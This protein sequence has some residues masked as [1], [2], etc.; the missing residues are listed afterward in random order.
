MH[1]LDGDS[2]L[3]VYFEGV[4]RYFQYF[5]VAPGITS[6]FDYHMFHL[7]ENINTSS[8]SFLYHKNTSYIISE[9]QIWIVSNHRV[10][11]TVQNCHPCQNYF[12]SM[13]LTNQVNPL[14]SIARTLALRINLTRIQTNTHTERPYRP[15][16]SSRVRPK[17]ENRKI[18]IFMSCAAHVSLAFL[19]SP[20]PP[21]HRWAR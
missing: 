11:L 12:K 16:E 2:D 8:D 7:W 19:D 3:C 13:D 17:T 10:S 15:Q 18:V 9:M 4:F 1:T 21:P 6:P 20:P 14:G 5:S